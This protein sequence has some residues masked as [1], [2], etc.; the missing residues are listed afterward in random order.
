MEGADLLGLAFM[1]SS[2]IIFWRF[3]AQTCTLLLRF[4]RS[5]DGMDRHKVFKLDLPIEEVENWTKKRNLIK[6]R[7][8][9]FSTIS[10]GVTR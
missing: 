1:F 2:F 10:E 3:C 4:A 9:G 6:V 7:F 5:V 8:L